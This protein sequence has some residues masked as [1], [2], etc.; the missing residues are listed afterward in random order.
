LWKTG[1][2]DITVLALTGDPAPIAIE[3]ND[4]PDLGLTTALLAQQQ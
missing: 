1:L 4:Q 3:I 2:N